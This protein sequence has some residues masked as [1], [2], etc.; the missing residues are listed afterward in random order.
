MF[1]DF[2]EFYVEYNINYNSKLPKSERL[3]LSTRF[4][5]RLEVFVNYIG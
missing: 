4:S 3:L 2:L 1:R 5:L